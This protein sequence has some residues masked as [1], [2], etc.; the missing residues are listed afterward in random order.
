[1]IRKNHGLDFFSSK[2]QS[3]LLYVWPSTFQKDHRFSIA[4]QSWKLKFQKR[5]FCLELHISICKHIFL[6]HHLCHFIHQCLRRQQFNRRWKRH[7]FR[8]TSLHVACFGMLNVSKCG[9]VAVNIGRIRYPNSQFSKTSVHDFSV[10]ISTDKFQIEKD[11]LIKKTEQDF[12]TCVWILVFQIGRTALLL[13]NPSDSETKFFITTCLI[14]KDQ[15][16]FPCTMAF[17]SEVSCNV[18][19]IGVLIVQSF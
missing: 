18:P 14:Q 17:D 15:K 1:M 4:L 5:A 2:S 13:M 11:R 8:K 19:C 10:N 9:S 12:L 6:L 16:I 3:M 7:F